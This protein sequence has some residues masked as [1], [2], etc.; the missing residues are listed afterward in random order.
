MLLPTGAMLFVAI[1]ELIPDAVKDLDPALTACCTTCAF[2][3]MGMVQ[4]EL[5]GVI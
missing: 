1:F 4:W 3:I 2:G 5:Y